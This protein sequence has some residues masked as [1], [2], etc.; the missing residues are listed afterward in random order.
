[1]TVTDFGVAPGASAALVFAVFF[2]VAA[3]FLAMTFDASNIAASPGYF[4][5]SVGFFVAAIWKSGLSSSRPTSAA[6]HAMA[7][8]AFTYEVN[9]SHALRR[10]R[11]SMPTVTD[12]ARA[13][14]SGADV[15]STVR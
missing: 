5:A 1:M 15:P 3:A 10:L 11:H 6:F 14:A 7:S 12:P 8:C 2:R 9:T 13:G 4:V